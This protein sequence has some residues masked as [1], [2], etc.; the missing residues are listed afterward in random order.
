MLEVFPLSTFTQL[1]C[2]PDYAESGWCPSL[3]DR[4]LDVLWDLG[5][6]L[7]SVRIQT[8][9]SGLRMKRYPWFI[10]ASQCQFVYREVLW[11][12]WSWASFLLTGIIC[13][14][15][16]ENKTYD[17]CKRACHPPSPHLFMQH[18]T[19]FPLSKLALQEDGHKH[20]PCSFFFLMTSIA[21]C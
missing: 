8:A 9:N 13:H 15:L 5:D 20:K 16:L 3:F 2:C 6:L 1:V 11:E 7:L 4:H 10:S 14:H 18:Y 12:N 19:F 21:M 17:Y